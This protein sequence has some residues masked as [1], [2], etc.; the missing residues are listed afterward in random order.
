[1]K[2]FQ[3]FLAAL[4]AVLIICIQPQLLALSA[5]NTTAVDTTSN[6]VDVYV[7]EADSHSEVRELLRRSHTQVSQRNFEAAIATVSEAIR[8]APDDSSLYSLRGRAYLRLQDDERAIA[9]YTQAIYLDPQN[10]LGYADRGFAHRLSQDYQRALKDLNEAIRLGPDVSDFYSE[11]GAV[12]E[13]L[14]DHRG[15][16]Q[17]YSQAIQLDSDTIRELKTDRI[18]KEVERRTVQH[19]IDR[20]NALYKLADKQ[21]AIEDYAQA[22]EMTTSTVELQTQKLGPFRAWYA[23]LVTSISLCL[24]WIISISLHE[25]GHAIVA[26]WGGDESVKTKGY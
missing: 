21:E 24:L 22:L 20:G 10:P 25:F 23:V 14:N 26:Y 5:V 9:D 6:T 17:D 7:A 11:R 16:V 4:F 2:P 19:Y 18:R 15:A 3:A 12:R 8:I 1:M 13:E